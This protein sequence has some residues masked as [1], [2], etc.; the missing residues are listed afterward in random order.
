MVDSTRPRYKRTDILIQRYTEFLLKNVTLTLDEEALRWARRKAAEENTSVSKLLGRMITEEMRRGDEYWKA[1][2]RLKRIK[3][4]PG[5]A[6]NPL[7][8][9]EANVR[10]KYR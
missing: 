3:P 4:I 6:S 1:Y 5:L 8:R 9:E 2:E 7:S 10:P